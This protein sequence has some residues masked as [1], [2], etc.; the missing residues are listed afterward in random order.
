MPTDSPGFGSHAAG[1][2]FSNTLAGRDVNPTS[3]NTENKSGSI[4]ACAFSTWAICGI[5]VAARF[6]ARGKIQHVLG[7]EDW[8]VLVAYLMSFGFTMATVYGAIYGMGSHISTVSAEDISKIIRTT[9]LCNLF[10]MLSLT[11]SKISILLLYTRLF[12]FYRARIAAWIMMAV[13]VIYNIWGLCVAFTLCI[14]LEAYWDPTVHGVCHGASYMWALIGLHVGTDFLIF[15]IPIPVV[16]SMMALSKRQKLGLVLLFALG[17]FVCI[18]SILR[19]VWVRQFVA[20]ADFLWDYV[21]INYWNCVEVNSAIVLPCMVVLKPLF[22]K[23]WPGAFSGDHDEIVDA[24]ASD[25]TPSD[26]VQLSDAAA[27]RFEKEVDSFLLKEPQ[28]LHIRNEPDQA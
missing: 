17:F 18:V 24:A 19:I 15:L 22:R 7:K 9:W 25:Q 8:C 4:I 27:W 2:M 20:S 10:Y 12:R 28:R 16:L 3:S 6:Y 11:F 21:Y 26:R 5:A 1:F 14:P 23:L 13:V